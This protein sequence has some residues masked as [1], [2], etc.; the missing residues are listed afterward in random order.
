MA[1]LTTQ[2]IVNAGTAPTF[3][4]A[5]ASDT[6]E[7]GNGVNTFVVYKNSDEA[8]RTV[9]VTV[10]GDTDYGQPTPDPALTL[11]ADDGE[12]WIPLRKAYDPSDGTGRATLAVTPSASGVTV[13]VVRLG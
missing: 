1:A 11:A 2:K 13:A 6:A 8:S 5:A 12:L 7:I 3:T 4:A 9:T 10:P